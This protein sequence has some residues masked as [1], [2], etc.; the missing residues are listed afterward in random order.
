MQDDG[1]VGGNANL[2]SFDVAG[3]QRC[4]VSVLSFILYARGSLPEDCFRAVSNKQ[5]ADPKITHEGLISSGKPLSVSGQPREIILAQD[6]PCIYLRNA[7]NHRLA[8]LLKALERV[9]AAVEQQRLGKIQICFTGSKLWDTSA[10]IEFY[11]LKLHYTKM[12]SMHIYISWGG[13]SDTPIPTDCRHPL[14]EFLRTRP[15]IRGTYYTCPFLFSIDGKPLD[16]KQRSTFRDGVQTAVSILQGNADASGGR[17][18]TVVYWST[19]DL[20]EEE[21]QKARQAAE[22]DLAAQWRA[23]FFREEYE[24]HDEDNISWGLN[25]RSLGRAEQSANFD[26]VPDWLSGYIPG[27]SHSPQ[28][29]LD[30]E[31]LQQKYD[32]NLPIKV[33]SKFSAVTRIGH[34]G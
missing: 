1:D 13:Q 15:P 33:A 2:A 16:D 11:S 23:D 18:G 3:A 28:R 12:G 17:I 7:E 10:L 5:W 34:S 25:H 20:F 14:K 22:A 26:D 31:V 27:P 9:F 24:I 21:K 32:C 29:Q 6:G 4:L 19:A 30:A 8:G